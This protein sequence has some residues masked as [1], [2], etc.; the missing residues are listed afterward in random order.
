MCVY[1]LPELSDGGGKVGNIGSQPEGLVLANR[2]L[3]TVLCVPGLFAFCPGKLRLKA[4]KQVVESPGQD[5]DVV[6][7]Q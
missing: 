6:D 3:H 2:V 1:S 5:H 4:L 7:V